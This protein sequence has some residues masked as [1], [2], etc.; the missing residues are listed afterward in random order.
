MRHILVDYS[1]R[2]SSVKRGG[3]LGRAPLEYAPRI[4]VQQQFDLVALDGALEQLAAF[5]PRKCQ[6]VEMRFFT[7]LRAKEIAGG[8]TPKTGI[9]G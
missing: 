1:R 4:A 5:D 2:R 8:V 6:V 3:G 9:C 7:G